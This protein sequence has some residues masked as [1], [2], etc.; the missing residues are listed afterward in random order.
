[1]EAKNTDNTQKKRKLPWQRGKVVNLQRGGGKGVSC[2]GWA[3]SPKL[4]LLPQ[5]PVEGEWGPRRFKI[6]G[7]MTSLALLTGSW[8]AL[9][10]GV[11]LGLL[12][13]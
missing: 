12:L 5:L 2:W 10:G 3:S 11:L 13:C 1:M 6:K 7:H 4:A 8:D 9:A